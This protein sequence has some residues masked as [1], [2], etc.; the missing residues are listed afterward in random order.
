MTD[1]TQKQVSVL[2]VCLGNICR[3]PMAE[4]VFK[5][6]VAK[7][8]LSAHFASIDSAGT[9]SYHV[10]EIPDRRSTDTCHKNGVTMNHKGRQ[11]TTSDYAK[12][13]WIL[14]MDDSNVSNVTSKKPQDTTCQISLLGQFDPHKSLSNDGHIIIDPY[15]G[16]IDGFQ[17]NFE[18]CRRASY[19]FLTHL[20]IE[21]SE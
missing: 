12:Y 1:S 4:A 6:V 14:C 19:G 20:G 13:D 11:I 17:L 18:Q 5:H 15:Y 21:Y 10:G 9:G 16:E 7:H 3:S 8:N 2:F